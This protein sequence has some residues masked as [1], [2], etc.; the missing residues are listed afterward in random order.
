MSTPPRYPAT[1]RYRRSRSGTALARPA[2]EEL[3]GCLDHVVDV[4]RRNRAVGKDAHRLA[5]ADARENLVN[6]ALGSPGRQTGFPPGD[7]RGRDFHAKYSPSNFD[8]P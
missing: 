3:I 7:E 1:F 2:D 8:S 4:A 6:A 5:R